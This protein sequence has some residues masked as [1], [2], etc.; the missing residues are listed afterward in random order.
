M[1]GEQLD[2]YL[3][4]KSEKFIRG[5]FDYLH[6]GHVYAE[7]TFEVFRENKELTTTF[8]SW[9]ISR[10]STGEL[11]KVNV[12]FTISKKFIPTKVIVDKALGNEI[13]K[14]EYRFSSRRNV[15]EYL[16]TNKKSGQ[17]KNLEFST[18][19]IFHI[20]VPA[21]CTSFLFIK[22]KKFDSTTKNGYHIFTSF[23]KW[24]YRWP[25]DSQMIFLERLSS[26]LEKVKMDSR[27]EVTGMRYRMEPDSDS[28]SDR[29]L[30]AMEVLLSEHSS[31]PYL[32]RDFP[33]SEGNI[34]HEVRIKYLNNLDN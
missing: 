25:P 21:A 4:P 23:N 32:I 12:D 14:E 5:A 19:P 20:M 27:N 9:L 7:E 8:K 30:P 15:I 3:K 11:L 13:V 29:S 16:F 2:Q 28:D 26:T 31:I 24:K 1:D 22:S 18:N 10:V 17:K 6:N 34:A 33:D